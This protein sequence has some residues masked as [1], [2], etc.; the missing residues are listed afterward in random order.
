MYKCFHNFTCTHLHVICYRKKL[1]IKI[2][3]IKFI[4]TDNNINEKK[5]DKN[6]SDKNTTDKN[7]ITIIIIYYCGAVSWILVH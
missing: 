2:L 7:T 1:L 3:L 5:N 6:T 4:T